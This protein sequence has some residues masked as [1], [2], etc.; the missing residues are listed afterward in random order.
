MYLGINCGGVPYRAAFI[1]CREERVKKGRMM[2]RMVI[3][4]SDR[5][6]DNARAWRITLWETPNIMP[7]YVY[8]LF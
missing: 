7:I 3:H 2:M 4:S 8:P 5:I 6:A 1:D